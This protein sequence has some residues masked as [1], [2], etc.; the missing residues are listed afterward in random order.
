M[1]DTDFHI[2]TTSM[3]NAGRTRVLKQANLFVVYDEDGDI[4][5]EGGGSHG[6]YMNDMRH[7]SM[8]EF[9]LWEQKPVLLSST[10]V[11]DN[12][13]LTVDLTNPELIETETQK[14]LERTSKSRR[15]KLVAGTQ[16]GG[17]SVVVEQGDAPGDQGAA[18]SDEGDEDQGEP[19]RLT[20]ILS[21]TLHIHR[22]KFVTEDTAHEK[23]RM[24]NYGEATLTVPIVVRF[25]AD[26]I[27]MFE[28]RGTPRDECGEFLETTVTDV[29]VRFGYIGLDHVQRETRVAFVQRPDSLSANEARFEFEIG[30]GQR[31]ELTYS[32]ECAIKELAHDAPAEAS[33]NGL[34]S[35]D[36]QALA[37]LGFGRAAGYRQAYAQMSERMRAAHTA[38]CR[39]DSSNVFYNLMLGRA[40]ADLQMLATETEHGLYPYAGTP[41]FNTVFGR[42]GLIC[43]YQVLNIRPE[44]SR[45][46]LGYLAAHQA[47]EFSDERDA[48]PGKILHEIRHD[49]MA[50]TGEVPFSYYYG[51]IDSTPLFV[52]LAGAY[53]RRS[54][55]LEFIKSIWPMIVKAIEWIDVY[56]DRDG[57]GYVE[58]G[59]RTAQGLRQ[60]GWK[61]SDDSVYHADGTLADAPIALCEVQGYVFA[62]R[63]AAAQIAEALGEEEYARAQR[64]QAMELKERFQRDFWDEALGTYVLAL[65]GAK[66]ACRVR[67][68]NAGHCLFSG[69]ATLERAQQVGKQLLEDDF[70][71][72]WGVRT[73]PL[74]QV[75][76]NPISYHN[77]SVWPHDNTM[78]AMGLARYGLKDEAL[79]IMA[80]LYHASRYFELNRMPEL[81]CGFERRPSEG[82]TLY[83]VACAP[84]AWAAGGVFLLLDAALGLYVDGRQG[85]VKFHNP[86]LPDFLDT[87][88]I[89]RVQVGDAMVDIELKRYRNDVG[90]QILKRRGK[91]EVMV[92]K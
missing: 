29:S 75:R 18:R 80:G 3:I 47:A 21:D 56:G 17:A 45:G 49:E 89:R 40:D 68:S 71:N 5:S 32:V 46:V 7:L 58:Y 73:M 55:D 33:E 92:V 59:R 35:G 51:S 44:I 11:E 88:R 6:L 34:D 1:T 85:L 13:L 23:I 39:F 52:A 37:R 12:S 90:V 4:S 8:L 30:P 25:E 14:K 81:F 65:D 63:R 20:R 27:D 28:V 9:R 79:R 69:I 22:S 42:D 86:R 50:N 24:H 31:R 64:R 57:D 70:F 76:Y 36:P 87:L 53:L 82:P 83:P 15:E 2:L 38:R 84:Q 74:G 26:F 16:T 77:G 54:G 41:W 78:I 19:V 62:A 61:D 10:I 66:R 43:A 48:E 60:Q 91:V 67:S 72:G